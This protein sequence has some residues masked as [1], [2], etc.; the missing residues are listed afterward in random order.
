M[1]IVVI[2]VLLKMLSFQVAVATLAK[3]LAH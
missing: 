2:V 1:I 3:K